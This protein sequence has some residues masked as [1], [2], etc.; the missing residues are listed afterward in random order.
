MAKGKEYVSSCPANPPDWYWVYGLH[1]AFITKIESIDFPFDYNKFLKEKNKYN[2]N[3]LSLEIDAK[4][5][6]Y[7]TSIEGIRFYNYKILT[8]CNLLHDKK[9]VC[10]KADRLSGQGDCFILEIDLLDIKSNL[11][12]FT[13]KIKFDRAEVDRKA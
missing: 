6:L 13:I 10:W 9:E 5:A 4:S 3:C 8:D 2:R 1:D 7:D 12:D 11:E